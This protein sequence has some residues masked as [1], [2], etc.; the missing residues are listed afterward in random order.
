MNGHSCIEP[1]QPA[2][3][4][5]A[6]PQPPPAYLNARYLGCCASKGC[7]GR[8]RGRATWAEEPSA[9]RN[10]DTGRVAE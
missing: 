1:P 5:M 6:E 7:G 3:A 10:A 8:G 9:W 4:H 2:G